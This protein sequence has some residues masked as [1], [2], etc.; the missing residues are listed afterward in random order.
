MGRHQTTI[1]RMN[2]KIAFV[3]DHL[4]QDGGAERV[5]QVMHS[6][7]ANVPTYVLVHDP[8]CANAFFNA[9]DIRTS[10]IQRMPGGV[11]HYQWFLVLMPTAVENYDLSEFDIVISTSSSF[12]KG[13]ITRPQTLHINYSHTPTRFLWSDTHS[14]LRDLRKPRWAKSLAKFALTSLRQWDY[15]AAQRPDVMLG[16][17]K[18]V[19]QRIQKYYHREARVLYPPVDVAQFSLSSDIEPYYLTGGRLVA[20]KNFD[21]VIKAFNELNIPLK[22]FGDGPEY[23]HLKKMAGSNVEMAGRVSDAERRKLYQHATAFINAQEED[24]GITPIEAMASGRPVIAYRAGG[25]LETVKEGETGVFFDEQAWEVL[26]DVVATFKPAAFDPEK[27]R[28]HAM[29]FSPEHF[30]EHLKKLVREEFIRSRGLSNDA[31][32]GTLNT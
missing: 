12:A 2:P 30:Q 26:A 3:H 24:F 19:Q 23:A 32:L 20:Y 31:D 29:Q 4:A 17:S 1:C 15:M 7:F 8:H 16:N 25:A 6:M 28:N 22:V 14:Y 21:M 13:V 18:A 5:L 10:F 9:K 27:I 11:K